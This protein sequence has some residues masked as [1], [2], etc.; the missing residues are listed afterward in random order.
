MC[1]ASR[2]Q[3]GQLVTLMPSKRCAPLR[4][5][6]LPCPQSTQVDA[7][8]HGHTSFTIDLSPYKWKGPNGGGRPTYVHVLPCPDVSQRLGAVCRLLLA[9]PVHLPPPSSLRLALQPI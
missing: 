3:L 4:L 6:C 8:Y 9:P 2:A 5:P 1:V 7:A